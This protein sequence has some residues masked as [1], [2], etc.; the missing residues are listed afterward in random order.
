VS[1]DPPAK[2]KRGGTKGR[3]APPAFARLRSGDSFS[4]NEIDVIRDEM[5]NLL[6]GEWRRHSSTAVRTA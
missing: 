6:M 2:G 1:I 4:P 5:T 3:I